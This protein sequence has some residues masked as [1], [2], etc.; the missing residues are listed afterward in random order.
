ME[1]EHNGQELDINYRHLDNETSF[2]LNIL[3]LFQIKI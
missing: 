2:Q 3:F 1:K